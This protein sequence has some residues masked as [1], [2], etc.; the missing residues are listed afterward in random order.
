MCR[1]MVAGGEEMPTA[2]PKM[3]SRPCWRP[4]FASATLWSWSDSLAGWI[5]LKASTQAL[6]CVAS[7][8]TLVRMSALLRA[9]G[10][11][12]GV[13]RPPVTALVIAG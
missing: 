7:V 1:A 11:V 10:V 12:G 9:G 6:N 2:S 4:S 5:R 13:A 3:R 8:N